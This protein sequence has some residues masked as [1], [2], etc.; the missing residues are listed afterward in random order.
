[1]NATPNLPA[2]H[3][4]YRP[5]APRDDA[6]GSP[7]H[8]QEVISFR[9][10]DGFKCNLVHVLDANPPTRGPVMLVHGAGVRANIFQAPVETT[11]VD[12]LIE[13]GYDVWLENWRASIDLPPNRWTLDQA[14]LFDHPKA[15]QTILDRTGA[16]EV[17]ALTHCQGSTSFL[18][19]AWAGLLPQ[20]PVIVSNGVSLHTV[21]PRFSVT[22]LRGSLPIV[23]RFTDYLNPR[24]GL[25]APTLTAKA[26]ALFVAATHHECDNPV[27][28]GV[29]FTYGS[30][31]PALWDHKH[32]ND[33]THEWLKREFAHVPISFFR[34]MARCVRRGSLVSVEGRTELPADF[35]K[36]SPRT[37]A[38]FAFFAGE[39]NRCFLPVSQER[40]HAHLE[41]IHPGRHTHHQIAN[42][43]HLDM[44]MGQDASRD[45]F[46]HMLAAL[47]R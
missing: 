40:T 31:F 32:L 26:V 39:R 8:R 18:M 25:H 15:I 28:K 23:G 43:G 42:Y 45:I 19:S 3:G 7:Q 9:A 27:C 11:I 35:A 22:K 29:S 38:T 12:A 17:K 2:S 20:V 44:F 14:A 36:A 33:E 16:T 41:A 1:M 6:R 47:D 5:V 21:V 30:G 37:E 24:W 46:P 34:Q 10:G 13:H 4:N